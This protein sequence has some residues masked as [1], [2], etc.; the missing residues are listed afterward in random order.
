MYHVGKRLKRSR[1]LSVHLY[2]R[3]NNILLQ[4]YGVMYFRKNLDTDFFHFSTTYV[5]E[6]ECYTFFSLFEITISRLES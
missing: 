3:V 4:V 5:I 6:K 1:F 2:F